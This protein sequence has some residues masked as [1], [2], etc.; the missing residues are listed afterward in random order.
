[1]GLE[2]LI[3]ATKSLVPKH[4]DILVQ[5]AGAG[6]M[7]RQ[8]ECQIEMLGLSNYVKLLGRVD[9]ERLPL[10]YRAADISVVP[11]VSLEGFGMITLES[12]ASGIPVMVTPVGG[13]PEV[14]SN[15]SPNLIFDGSGPDAIARGISQVL[16]GERVLPDTEECRRHAETYYTWP[17]VARRT[18]QVYL[19]ALG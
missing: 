8:L 12:L 4:S 3:L 6:E 14:V 7:A 10:A 15:L 19:E 16:R 1:M 2:D 9:E 13:L 11:T 18:R 5:V 17:S